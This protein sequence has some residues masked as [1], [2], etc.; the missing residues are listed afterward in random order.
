MCEMY[1]VRIVTYKQMFQGENNTFVI[2]FVAGL[3]SAHYN[4]IASGTFAL[5]NLWCKRRPIQIKKI[6]AAPRPLWKDDDSNSEES[7]NDQNN[8][9]DQNVEQ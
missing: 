8:F 5:L 3:L 4:S 1:N 6:V 2:G 9:F 7:S